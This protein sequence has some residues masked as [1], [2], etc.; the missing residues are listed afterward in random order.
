MKKVLALL[1]VLVSVLFLCSCGDYDETDLRTE[2]G[3]GYEDGFD[4]GYDEGS[5]EGYREG[6]QEGYDEGFDDGREEERETQW[7]AESYA[8]SKSGWNPEEA[9]GIIDDYKA[10]SSE[11]L[12]YVPT[13]SDYMAA[14][15]S[16]YYFYEYYCSN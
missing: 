1:L 13:W 6:Y 7:S 11:Y 14:I 8:R 4:A 15:D 2:R 5:S 3:R 16:L 9:L 12:G 10:G